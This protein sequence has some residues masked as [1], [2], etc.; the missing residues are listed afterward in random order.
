MLVPLGV[1]SVGAVLAGFVFYKPFIY[2]EEGAAF[3]ASSIAFDVHL[4]HAA[5]DVPL[6]VKWTP[7]TVMAIGLLIAWNNYVRNPSLPARFVEHFRLIHNFLYRKWYFDELYDLIFV[8]PSFWLGRLLWKR[9][10]EGTIDRFGPDGAAALVQGGTRLAVK[11]QSG[12]L[13][14]YAF[15]MLLGLVGLVSWAMVKFQ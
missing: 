11:F 8:R 9:G 14:G 5:H 10:D 12:Y 2:A 13:Y 3:W 15:V 6:W 4:M 1:L 7:F